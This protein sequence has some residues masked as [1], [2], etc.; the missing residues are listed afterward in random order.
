MMI[1]SVSSNL[2]VIPSIRATIIGSLLVLLKI[3]SE[4]V[5]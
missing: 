3:S 5:E 2:F 4:Q 1:F